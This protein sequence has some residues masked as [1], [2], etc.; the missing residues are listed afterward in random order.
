M[1]DDDGTDGTGLTTSVK[2]LAESASTT[3]PG[4]KSHFYADIEWSFRDVLKLGDCIRFAEVH[5][6]LYTSSNICAVI[7]QKGW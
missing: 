3:C 6:Y 2:H 5:E 4:F 1:R 7:L